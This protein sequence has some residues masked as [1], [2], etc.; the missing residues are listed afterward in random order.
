MWKALN[1]KVPQ[2]L[3]DQLSIRVRTYG[4]NNAKFHLALANIN[5]FKRDTVYQGPKL[6]NS[7]PTNI[8][9]KASVP[10]FK[11]AVKKHFLSYK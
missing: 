6:W 9:N 1:G 5:L 10:T 4:H 11:T 8:K 3:K 7:V 2:T